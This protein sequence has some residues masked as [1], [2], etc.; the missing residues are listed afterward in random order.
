[1]QHL[2]HDVSRSALNYDVNSTS[3]ILIMTTQNVAS[4]YP[5]PPDYYKRYTEENLDIL[6]QVKEQGEEAFVA[7]GGT[8][9]QNFNILELEP[10][11]PITEGH[12]YTFN[13]K[14]PVSYH[15]LRY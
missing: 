15:F 7:S 12:Y 8:L 10:P 11:A 1:L 3:F 13:E 14:W 2:A 4:V 5:L 9:P 6:K